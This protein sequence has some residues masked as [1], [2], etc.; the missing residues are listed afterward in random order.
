MKKV[1]VYTVPVEVRVPHGTHQ[2]LVTTYVAELLGEAL[3]LCDGIKEMSEPTEFLRVIGAMMESAEDPKVLT[4]IGWIKKCEFKPCASQFVC[5]EG[6][7]LEFKL[8]PDEAAWYGDSSDG[9]YV[10]T[11]LDVE[12]DRFWVLC[13]VDCDSTAFV[14]T[15]LIDGPFNTKINAEAAGRHAAI[16][17]CGDNGVEII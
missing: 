2:A 6:T 8:D 17:W 15:L 4:R 7:D 12:D 11:F 16:E 5:T 1:D 9:V 3:N 14:D 13:V 10:Q